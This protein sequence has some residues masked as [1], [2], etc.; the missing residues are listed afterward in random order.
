[1][2]VG[3]KIFDTSFKQLAKRKELEFIQNHIFIHHSKHIPISFLT[4]K[5]WE[6]I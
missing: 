4:K 6:F 2:K 3:R 1:M 5:K